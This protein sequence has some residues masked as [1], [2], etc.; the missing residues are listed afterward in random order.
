MTFKIKYFQ[1]VYTYNHLK[2][3]PTLYIALAMATVTPTCSKYLSVLVLVT[4][5][6]LSSDKDSLL[7][8]I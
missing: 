1:Y 4:C 6:W 8:Q 2:N 7:N 3:I 5:D